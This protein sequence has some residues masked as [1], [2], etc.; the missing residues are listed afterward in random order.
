M[1]SPDRRLFIG[2]ALWCLLALIS[3]LLSLPETLQAIW[4]LLG[5]LLLGLG[6][7][8]LWL[9]RRL[10]QP[11]AERI[12]PA[13]FALHVPGE[14][15]LRFQSDTLPERFLVADH[16][17]ADDRQTGLPAEARRASTGPTEL[18]YRY[19]PGQRG[20]A[21]FGPLDIWRTSPLQLWQIRQRIPAS[22][23][24]PVYPDFSGL[25]P[26]DMAANRSRQQHGRHSRLRPGDGQEFHQLR[27]Y[28]PG[29]TLRQI[30]WNATAR[31]RSLISREYREE[32]SQP[33]IILLDCS[34]RMA[35]PAAQ[36]L[37]F[38]HALNA[39]LLLASSALA[40]GDQPGLLAL[41]GEQPI[42]LP[43]FRSRS[44]LNRMLH[45]LYP[46]Q[47]EAG[48][49]DF[50]AAAGALLQRYRR[51]ATVVLIS[52]LQPDDQ[53]D[54]LIASQL[55]RRQ[56]RLLV[57]DML[58]PLQQHLHNTSVDNHEQA[59]QVAAEARYQQERQELHARLRHAGVVVSEA[60]PAQMG[61]RL[62]QTYL[63]LKRGNRL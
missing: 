42:W 29:D 22:R 31:R 9:S 41:T 50:Q 43:P 3:V 35:T 34:A 52:Q 39:S 51:R 23:R 59:L 6:L 27:E 19:R 55:L 40:G 7:I 63:Q 44:G 58:L 47:P 53:D 37:A 4:L 10:A 46:L 49:V 8:D 24:V 56:H 26:A 21:D 20:H 33:L 5:G 17:P 38:D 13:A 12:L 1:I 62:E 15:I 14:V 57:G 32:N 11:V 54:L 28:R 16:H 48:A 2:V 61:V 36:L 30:D 45:Q 18:H 25:M 60:L